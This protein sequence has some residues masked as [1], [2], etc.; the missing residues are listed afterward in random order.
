MLIKASKLSTFK[1]GGGDPTSTSPKAGFTWRA[2]YT[3]G[4]AEVTAD[5]VDKSSSEKVGFTVVEP[6]SLTAKK[7]KD[8]AFP[9]GEQGAGMVLQFLY[10]PMNVSFGGVEA[11][12]RSGPASDIDGY[13]KH[14]GMPHKHDATPTFA[15]I[16]ANNQLSGET[17]DSASQTGMPPPWEKGSFHW[18]IPNEFRADEEATPKTFT[19]VKQEFVMADESGT[20]TVTKAGASVTRKP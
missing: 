8:K 14:E 12:E 11:R 5:A 10:G 4:A 9:A 15:T 19:I 1:A 2:P 20:T 17:R 3:A 16:A 6:S 7:E 13:Y 18:E